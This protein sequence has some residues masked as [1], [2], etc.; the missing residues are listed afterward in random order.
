MLLFL[1]VCLLTQ[2]VFWAVEIVP[3]MQLSSSVP[4]SGKKQPAIHHT[5]PRSSGRGVTFTV[6]FQ[7]WQNSSYRFH[8]DI[9]VTVRHRPLDFQPWWL[10]SRHLIISMCTT[11]KQRCSDMKTMWWISDNILQC[12]THI[13]SQTLWM[14]SPGAYRSLAKRVRGVA[15]MCLYSA[16]VVLGILIMSSHW[17][18]SC[19]S[20]LLHKG[21]I[22]GNRLGQFIYAPNVAHHCPSPC[23]WTPKNYSQ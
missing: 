1:H 18:A 6:S 8:P 3:R 23:F 2:C 19:G 15:Y 7:L 21:G 10:Y 16:S 22:G 17:H 12:H 5:S 9:V 4:I 13:G 11:T 14:Y 20:Q